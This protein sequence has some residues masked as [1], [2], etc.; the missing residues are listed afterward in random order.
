MKN[1]K[2]LSTRFI[3]LFTTVLWYSCNDDPDDIPMDPDPV[4]A[5]G[6]IEWTRSFGGSGEDTPRSVIATSDGG[7]AILGFSNSTDGDLAGKAMAVNDYWLLKL[8]SDGRTEWQRTLGGSK[9][10]RGQA[11]IQTLDGGYAVSGYAMSDDGDGSVNKGFHDNWIVRLD[12]GGNILWERSFGYSGHDHSYDLAQTEDG[13]FLF[14]GFMDLSA[15][16]VD[17]FEGLSAK[18]T[19]SSQHGVGEFWCTRLFSDGSLDWQ[20][21]FGGSNN[22][23]A[24]A[25][26]PAGDG[27]FALAGF[28]E[29]DDFDISQARGSYDFWVIRIS[30]D[31]S[32]I[33]ERSLGE[34]E[35]TSLL[36]LPLARMVVSWSLATP[37]AQTVTRP[38]PLGNRISGW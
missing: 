33:W 3:V 14:A 37:S 20:F 2:I 29:S 9:D 28:S 11:V 23:R 1:F 16:R 12:G 7:L 18:G 31:G 17:G 24:H 27:G 32:M 5:T 15:A 13:G 19:A 4:A 21:Y 8:D 38:N 10:D 36:I 35:L 30:D 34:V 25:L 22:D 6:N 26:T